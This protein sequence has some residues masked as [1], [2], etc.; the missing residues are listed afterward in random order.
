MP[1]NCSACVLTYNSGKTIRRCLESVKNFTDIVILDG[2][3]ADETLD[4]AKS[5]GARIFPQQ[6]GGGPAKITD[7]TAVREKLF[8]L[9][10]EDWRLWL[11]SDEWLSEEA[12]EKIKNITDGR[13]EN[14][15]YSLERKAVIG[16]TPIEYAYFYP[17]YCNRLFNK[18]SGVSLKKGK[19]VHEDLVAGGGVVIEKIPVLIYHQW[20]DNYRELIE[21]DNHYLS[22]TVE[23]KKNFYFRKRARIA[24]INILKGAKVIFKSLLIY[25][26]H[27]F[28]N[29]LPV[30]YSWRFARYHFVYA[31]KI[32]LVGAASIR[33]LNKTFLMAVLGGVL[34]G[35]IFY[36]PNF[37]IK[38]YAD[39]GSNGVYLA[40]VSDPDEGFAYGSRVREAMDGDF[41]EGD[42]YLWE[43]KNMPNIW[44]TN[45]AAAFFGFIMR[46]FHIKYVDI[47]FSLGDFI[48]P[49]ILFLISF[50]LFFSVTKKRLYSILSALIMLSFPGIFTL[51]VRNLFNPNFYKTLSFGTFIS[52]FGTA[53]NT[54]LSRL[55]VP[56]FY[57]I[58]ILLFIYCLYAAAS[59]PSRKNIFLTGFFFGLLFYLYLYYWVFAFVLLVILGLMLLA[60]K[61]REPSR[62]VF[63]I[64]I[65]G[66]IISIPFW[67]KM[68]YLNTFP[69]YQEY[70]A[71]AGKQIGRNIRW[72]SSGLYILIFILAIF[73]IF[74]WIKKKQI[75]APFVLSLLLT[76]AAVL[77][78]QLI[79][80]FNIQP[81]HWGSRIG[82]YMVSFSI[83][84]SIYLLISLCFELFGRRGFVAWFKKRA[85]A[86]VL[87]L[88]LFI[89]E[90]AV[91]SQIASAKIKYDDYLLNK[92]IYGA[93][94]WLNGNSENGSVIATPSVYMNWIIPIITHNNIY[95][96]TACRSMAGSGEIITRFQEI[97]SVF[98]VREDYLKY[99]FGVFPP[100]KFNAMIYS[101][102]YR[103]FLFCSVVSYE[104]KIIEAKVPPEKFVDDFLIGYK[105]SDKKRNRRLQFDFRADYLFVG[106]KE[107]LIS[108]FDPDKYDNLDMVFYNGSVKIYKIK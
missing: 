33:R 100:D 34:M 68:H 23:E 94:E 80:G 46:A 74:Y 42:P 65:L 27:G 70:A 81:D 67:I 18:N 38:K 53:F 85:N 9:A 77:N 4:V 108:R 7:F 10:K 25:L 41:N 37:Y 20:N 63:K 3:S 105:I 98:N 51:A 75:I 89:G 6:E 88:I 12:A 79:L 95:L 82:A 69:L 93:A 90:M 45:Y 107:K 76:S 15:L 30:P 61:Y 55:F 13:P 2:G 43:Y 28:K 66:A 31:K 39:S 47:L 49:F 96:P 35:A 19:K 84:V 40:S 22:L 32:L 44:E 56:G 54:G 86:S 16:G 72:E 48:F 91:L 60:M 102:S 64:F 58:F 78:L 99:N 92:D 36:L 17:E 8:S 104:K 59:R 52:L 50:Y 26:R 87:V 103:E 11:D 57:L 24:F 73:L 106:P 1:T 29:T 83:L 21:K 5:F 14:K 97:N 62:A 71:R 101:D